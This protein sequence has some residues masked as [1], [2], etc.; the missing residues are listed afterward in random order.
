M[1]EKT[2]ATIQ[3]LFTDHHICKTQRNPTKPKP[4][5]VTFPPKNNDRQPPPRPL[6]D[7]SEHQPSVV[8]CVVARIH[9]G[10]GQ[11]RR[12]LF[13][14]IF[15]RPFFFGRQPW[16]QQIPR[17]KEKFDGGFNTCFF[18]TFPVEFPPEPSINP[19]GFFVTREIDIKSTM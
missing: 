19:T 17:T 12:R 4:P 7:L 13:S 16:W 15:R 14:G 6:H 8:L 2:H 5:F 11:S 9:H 10:H 1:D 3:P 18:T